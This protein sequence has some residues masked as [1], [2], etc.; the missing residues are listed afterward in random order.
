MTE[1][2]FDSVE[3]GLQQ[4]RYELLR[5]RSVSLTEACGV[6][7]NHEALLKITTGPWFEMEKRRDRRRNT[8][9]YM[10]A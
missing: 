5:D 1:P 9:R 3:P 7:A 10:E 6:S 2:Q 8:Q 4:Q